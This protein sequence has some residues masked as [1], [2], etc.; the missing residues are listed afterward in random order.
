VNQVWF[1]RYFNSEL[2]MQFFVFGSALVLMCNELNQYFR[3]I[4]AAVVLGSAFFARIDAFLFLPGILVLIP[5][6][7][8]KRQLDKRLIF[9]LVAVLFFLLSIVYGISYCPMYIKPR[10]LDRLNNGLFIWCGV[11]LGAGIF[12]SYFRGLGNTMEKAIGYGPFVL[13]ILSGILLLYGLLKRR[14]VGSVWISLYFPHAAIAAGLAGLAIIAWKKRKNMGEERMI[15]IFMT[16]TFFVW[17]VIFLRDPQIQ[18]DH[19]WA[20]RRFTAFYIPFLLFGFGAVFG[21]SYNGL[22]IIKIMFLSIFFCFAGWYAYRHIPQYKLH[23]CG[24]IQQTINTISEVFPDKS[25]IF[26]IE[27][28]PVLFITPIFFNTL[29]E[30]EKTIVPVAHP[31][32]FYAGDAGVEGIVR[33]ELEQ[34]RRTF[35]ASYKDKYA[36]CNFKNLQARHYKTIPIILPY[37]EMTR[38]RLPFRMRESFYSMIID[39]LFLTEKN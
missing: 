24:G 39:E 10:L 38:D 3:Y 4:G 32:Q 16:L 33:N 1:A 34:G 23:G 21:L 30:K 22:K 25:T 7:S 14:F 27:P 6:L 31:T 29:H 37:A 11:F 20:I 19:F 18:P 12:W 15:L 9:V 17:S 8:E 2:L 5:L 36:E 13:N 35:I 28:P 26:F